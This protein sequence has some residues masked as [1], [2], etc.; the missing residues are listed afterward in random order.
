MT[1]TI[2]KEDLDRFNELISKHHHDRR[3]TMMKFCR[4]LMSA[5][6]DW[7]SMSIAERVVGDFDRKMDEW[8]KLNP[9]PTL[10]D[11]LK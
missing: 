10:L 11:L 9:A 2:S 5:M 6:I 4:E 7:R 3:Q 1:I 8:D